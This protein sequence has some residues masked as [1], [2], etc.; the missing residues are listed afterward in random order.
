MPERD[1]R[2]SNIEDRFVRLNQGS[3]ARL[4][5]IEA[6]KG[7]GDEEILVLDNPQTT[8]FSKIQESLRFFLRPVDRRVAL[9]VSVILLIISVACSSNPDSGIN[10]PTV[11][12]PNIE[13]AGKIAFI[14]D[15][16]GDPEIYLMD[17]DGSNVT[18]VTDNHGL[19]AYQDDPWSPDGS[20]LLFMS[21]RNG[22][23]DIFTINAD[24]SDEMQIT[25]HPED[26]LWPIWSPNGEQI[27][28]T[29]E[30][31][32]NVEI[33][34]VNADGSGLRNLTN[35]Q[36]DEGALG[37]TW[38]P[39]GTRLAYSSNRELENQLYVIDINGENEKL[40]ARG[41]NSE[42]ILE[43]YW[44]PDGGSIAF[45]MTQLMVGNDIFIVDIKTNDFVHITDEIIDGANVRW[46]PDGSLLLFDH[47][48]CF[49]A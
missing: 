24:G 36:A 48:S 3:E 13:T 5:Q 14:S 38:S 43:S 39:D 42:H 19:D 35:N 1:S 4:T 11:N 30:R 21:D 9:P 28:F 46:S 40:V 6:A 22:N 49:L 15:R 32:G 31:D 37:F 33:Y 12:K 17:Q 25:D 8:L 34:I 41:G 44:S 23:V 26:D 10:E 27:A 18:N 2:Q 29:T 16:E 45:E 7:I 20:K 47:S